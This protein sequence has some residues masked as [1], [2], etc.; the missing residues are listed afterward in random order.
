MTRNQRIVIQTL[1]KAPQGKLSRQ[2][3]LQKLF[4][5]DNE[6]MSFGLNRALPGLQK[7]VDTTVENGKVF[8]SLKSHYNLKSR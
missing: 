1:S 3:L 6:I 2:Q 7:Y 5:I 4:S 8:Y